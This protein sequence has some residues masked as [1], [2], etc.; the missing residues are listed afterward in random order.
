MERR[1]SP[2]QFVLNQSDLG[3]DRWIPW[4][5]RWAFRDFFG[6][7]ASQ[8]CPRAWWGLIAQCEEEE[9]KGHKF[10]WP[11]AWERKWRTPWLPCFEIFILPITFSSCSTATPSSGT[12]AQKWHEALGT[13]WIKIYPH[14]G[15]DFCWDPGARG[16]GRAQGEALRFLWRWVIGQGLK[17]KIF[18][19]TG[20]DH[21][22]HVPSSSTVINNLFKLF[23]I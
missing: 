15:E 21:L 16:T 12:A 22:S 14:G 13:R 7:N 20:L 1:G 18:F 5:L 11:P 6:P 23:I 17:P 19:S 3:W 9:T 8:G 4:G 10:W 2:A